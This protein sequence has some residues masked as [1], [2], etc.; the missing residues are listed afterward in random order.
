ML[1]QA[2]CEVLRG[3]AKALLQAP[4]EDLLAIENASLLSDQF[5]LQDPVIIAASRRATRA[6]MLHWASSIYANP[7]Q[8]VAVQMPEDLVNNALEAAR[9]GA[10]ST[11]FKAF[12]ASQDAAWRYWMQIVFSHCQN[13]AHLHTLLQVSSA[14]ISAFLDAT[15]EQLAHLMQQERERHLAATPAQRHALITRLLDGQQAPLTQLTNHL[16]YPFA[17]THLAAVIWSEQPNIKDRELNQAATLLARHIGSRAQ[18]SSYAKQ[19]CLWVWLADPQTSCL[20]ALARGLNGSVRIA[21]GRAGQGLAGFRQSHQDALST[22]KLMA[23]NQRSL[24]CFAD[25]A[26]IALLDPKH[27]DTLRF[28]QNTLG[29]LASAETVL[30]KSLWVYLRAGCNASLAAKQLHTHRNTLLRRLADAQSRLPR[31]LT[32]NLLHLGTALEWLL[33]QQEESIGA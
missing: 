10:R 14:S 29:A 13:P 28:I 8:P 26:L 24:A 31:P 16:G 23:A 27:P 12:R 3:C 20:D 33:W 1:D 7:N 32:E 11:V 9:N 5:A 30:L 25:V 18:L 2:L 17:S 21:I 22:Q 15:L 19:A 6:G 4:D